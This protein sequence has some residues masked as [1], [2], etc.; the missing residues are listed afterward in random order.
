M[1]S[2]PTAGRASGV[3]A[4]LPSI[5]VLRTVAICLMIVVHFVENLAA[6]HDACR[7]R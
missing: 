7:W 5:D 2:A 1:T 4:R 6:T 3:E